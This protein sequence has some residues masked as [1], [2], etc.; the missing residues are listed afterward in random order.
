MNAKTL[1]IIVFILIT[2]F[3]SGLVWSTFIPIWQF[4]D[5]QAHFAQVQNYAEFKGYLP[6]GSKDLSFEIFESEN[7][8]GTLRD[9]FGR[10]KFTYN[11]SFNIK[12][13]DSKIGLKEEYLNNLPPVARTT[14]VKNESPLYP[15]L[16]YVLSTTGYFAVNS[17]N[18]FARVVATRII[19]VL[20]LVV[21]VF[22]GFKFSQELF[23][24]KK[25]LQLATTLAIAFHPMLTF[26]SSGINNDTLLNLLTTALLFFLV[27]II[28]RGITPKDS[29]FIAF[30]FALGALTKQLIYLFVPA[31]GLAILFSLKKTKLTKSQTKTLIT[32][33]LLGLISMSLLLFRRGFWWP[34][35]PKVSP[36]SPG[37]HLSFFSL[38]LERISQL[39]RETLPWY[40]GVYK[41]LGV[42][43]PLN[44]IRIIKV[45]MGLSFIG[46]LKYLYFKFKTKKFTVT[47]KQFTLLFFANIV[48]ITVLVAWDISLHRNVGFG[49]GIQGRYF[50]PLIASHMAFLVFGLWQLITNGKFQ[51]IFLLS[52]FSLMLILNLLSLHR[53]LTSYYTLTSFTSFINQASQYKPSFAKWPYLGVYFTAYILSL[54]LLFS[55][56][57]KYKK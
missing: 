16:F 30:I 26:V 50:F 51:K 13:S 36:N 44:V 7:I 56:L 34:F 40:W 47:D 48:Y 53:V 15:P 49:H 24:Q 31:I 43:L 11:P 45:F 37:A 55:K 8:L 52:I 12:Y 1:P 20:M 14:L 46:W 22:F 39:Y 38:L 2:A 21:L 6:P 28:R 9:K 41:W 19:S 57:F 54:R 35:W 18:L 42:V 10:N 32:Y 3:L 27:K 5:E 25:H 17:Q 33:S 4:P 29:F 23:P